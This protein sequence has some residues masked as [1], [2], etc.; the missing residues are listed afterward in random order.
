MNEQT[1]YSAAQYRA[2]EAAAFRRGVEAMQRTAVL[3]CSLIAQR[4]WH[5][6]GNPSLVEALSECERAIAALPPPEDKG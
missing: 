2:A 5:K 6:T 3:E 1:I 4:L